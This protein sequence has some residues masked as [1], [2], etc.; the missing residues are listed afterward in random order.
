MLNKLKELESLEESSTGSQDDRRG[1]D[2]RCDISVL[3]VILNDA[4]TAGDETQFKLCMSNALGSRLVRS[5]SFTFPLLT[6][7]TALPQATMPQHY[8]VTHKIEDQ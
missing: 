6:L 5:S 7:L 3:R 4:M 8:H 2:T 1:C